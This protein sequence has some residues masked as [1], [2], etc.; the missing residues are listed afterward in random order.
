MCLPFRH[1]NTTRINTYADRSAPEC[2][3]SGRCISV[4]TIDTALGELRNA[5]E[6]EAQVQHV[7]I[8]NDVVSAMMLV[9]G[10]PKMRLSYGTPCVLLQ[11]ITLYHE[12][13]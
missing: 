11:S 8:T 10:S 1:T 9:S 5:F 12:D 4:A 6:E 7:H 13:F 2:L 3:E